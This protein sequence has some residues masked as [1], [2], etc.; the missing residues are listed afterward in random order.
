MPK[1]IYTRTK[2]ARMNMS[3]V[4]RGRI[5]WNKGKKITKTLGKNNGNWKGDSVGYQGVHGWIRRTLG[6]PEL[7]EN[8]GTN[9]KTRYEWAN[10]SGDYKRDISDWARLCVVCHRLIDGNYTWNNRKLFDR[11][12][13]N[14]TTAFRPSSAIRKFC[15]QS[16]A[17]KYS[18]AIRK[19]T[20]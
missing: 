9:R 19:G 14:C 11:N 1:G 18:W 6:T 16:C 15:S 3:Q 8:C 4:Q 12:C 10:L 5:P 7:C 20:T 17:G 13:L 2:Q